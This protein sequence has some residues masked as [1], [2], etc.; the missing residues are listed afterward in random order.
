MSSRS[1][2]VWLDDLHTVVVDDVHV[3]VSVEQLD[4]FLA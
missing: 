4:T 1:A 3:G 2:K